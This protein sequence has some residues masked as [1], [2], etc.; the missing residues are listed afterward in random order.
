MFVVL[1]ICMEERGQ[2]IIDAILRNAAY[3]LKTGSFQ[4]IKLD[5]L[6]SVSLRVPF[7]SSSPALELPGCLLFTGLVFFLSPNDLT[8]VSMFALYYLSFLYKQLNG[9][10]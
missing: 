5:L 7:T 9:E 4:L 3:P 2:P 1:I 8:Q 10:F 6:S